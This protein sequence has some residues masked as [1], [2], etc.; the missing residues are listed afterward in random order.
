MSEGETRE[1]VKPDVV[2]DLGRTICLGA[3]IP[4]AM[5][6]FMPFQPLFFFGCLAAF[7]LPRFVFRKLRAP[8]VVHWSRRDSIWV[9]VAVAVTIAYFSALIPSRLASW[10]GL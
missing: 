3:L 8:V 1:P 2:R 7:V 6:A 4:W 5:S 10:L 9:L